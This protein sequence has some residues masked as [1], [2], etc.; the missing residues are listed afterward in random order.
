MNA[1][2]RILV[3]IFFIPVFLFAEKNHDK[4]LKFLAKDEHSIFF[5]LKDYPQLFF[6]GDSV[7]IS[8]ENEYVVENKDF[9]KNITFVTEVNTNIVNKDVSPRNYYRFRGNSGKYIC[10]TDSVDEY[11]LLRNKEE[12][13]TEQMIFYL[14]ESS[15]LMSYK[16]GTY[17]TRNNNIGRIGEDRG[18]FSIKTSARY[19]NKFTIAVNEGILSDKGDFISSDTCYK[20]RSNEWIIEKVDVLPVSISSARYRTL[21][22]PVTLEVPEGCL[23]YTVTL[24]KDWVELTEIEGGIIPANTG[25]IIYA[26]QPDTYFFPISN[27]SFI[28]KSDLMG[29]VAATYYTSQGKYFVLA[30]VDGELGFYKAMVTNG[31]FLNNSHRAFL[32][33]SSFDENVFYSVRF[34]KDLTNVECISTSNTDEIFDLRGRKLEKITSPGV[35]IVNGCKKIVK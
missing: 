19:S 27:S 24:K 9:V 20:D 5:R 12:L 4:Y 13:C 16:T 34:S 32:Y 18:R 1:Y 17:I 8:S 31:I 25:V 11:L 28:L 33:L 21:Y 2:F 14:N 6:V 3:V 35:Y 22:S 15:N 10:F 23:A 30:E 26:E 29:S 7:C